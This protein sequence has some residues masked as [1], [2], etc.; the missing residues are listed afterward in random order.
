MREMI[1][2]KGVLEENGE[3]GSMVHVYGFHSK[4][5]N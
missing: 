2:Y 1:I 4:H 5:V 3:Q